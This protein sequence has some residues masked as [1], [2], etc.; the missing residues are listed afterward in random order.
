LLAICMRQLGRIT[1]SQGTRLLAERRLAARTDP[2]SQRTFRLLLDKA[3]AGVESRAG[4]L[5]ETLGKL[6]E[7][8]DPIVRQALA[9]LQARTDL[10]GAAEERDVLVNRFGRLDDARSIAA[11]TKPLGQVHL[12]RRGLDK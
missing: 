9:R 4:D 6:R 11:E 10:S 7:L 12:A 2:D 1:E 5:D 8:P 3:T